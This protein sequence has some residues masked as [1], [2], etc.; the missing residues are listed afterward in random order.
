MD[1]FRQIRID[2][3]SGAEAIHTSQ[4]TVTVIDVDTFDI[5]G[6]LD[7]AYIAGGEWVTIDHSFIAPASPTF[8]LSDL[9]DVSPDP[10]GSNAGV[11]TVNFTEPVTNVGIDDFRL[12]RDGR[13]VD[14]S[15]ISVIQINPQQYT[16]DLSSATTE[17]GQYEL[18]VDN[19]FPEAQIIAPSATSLLEPIG[20]VTINFTEDVTGVDITD[21]IL[22]RDVGD[23]NGSVAVNL[24]G[25]QDA[26][27]VFGSNLAVA[28][29][30][31]SQYT[32]DLTGIT[33][34][35]G[36]YRLSLLAPR[37][38]VTVDPITQTNVAGNPIVVRSQSPHGL[39]TGMEVTIDE[40]LNDY[41]MG[42]DTRPNGEKFIITV[43]DQF[44]FEL[45]GTASDGANASNG[46]WRFDPEIVDEVGRPYGIDNSSRNDP[47]SPILADAT[48]AWN[49]ANTAPVADIV[50]ISPDPRNSALNTARVVFSEPVRITQVN[51][52]DF[53]LTR[54]IGSGP[55]PL[56]LTGIASVSAIDPDPTGSFA[57]TFELTSLALFTGQDATYRLRLITTD[58][59]RITDQ[60]GSLLQF[61]ATDEW[62]MVTTGPAPLVFPVFPDPRSNQP[63]NPP[64]VIPVS[65]NESVSGVDLVNADTHFTLLRDAGDGN[66]PQ[67]VPL[68]DP[69]N[70]H[71]DSG[72]DDQWDGLFS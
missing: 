63:T 46:I 59:S 34:E 44:E 40:V 28:Q 19:T 2:G 33:N 42:A 60:Q 66:G 67:V 10:L 17:E 21:F 45:N 7:D 48:I 55:V 54:D 50:D 39:S 1:A 64:L 43:L 27:G 35:V 36:S 53:R 56:S 65:F 31:A 69:S 4:T 68:V 14:I 61:E 38:D 6:A 9:I 22:T 16:L 57:T 41:A 30:S 5:A 72:H 52:S 25:L 13:P 29:V 49:R 12:T 51:V 58:S 8:A 32:I 24:T 26:N 3:V 15:A 23:G 11:V 71:A 37:A 18:I 20:V 62:V 47:N 70:S